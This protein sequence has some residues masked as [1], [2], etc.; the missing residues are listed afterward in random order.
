VTEQNRHL[1]TAVQ[2]YLD[3]AKEHLD[4]AAMDAVDVAPV[5]VATPIMLRPAEGSAPAG[6]S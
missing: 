4:Q 6:R 3:A 1:F 2:V 5:V